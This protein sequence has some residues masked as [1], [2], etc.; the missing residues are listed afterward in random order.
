MRAVTTEEGKALAARFGASFVEV[1]SKTRENVRTP[2]VD[3]VDQIV[4]NPD[5]MN[6]KLTRRRREGAV[7]TDQEQEDMGMASCVC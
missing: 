3:M 4:E 2:F 6:P 1:S 5:L 7:S